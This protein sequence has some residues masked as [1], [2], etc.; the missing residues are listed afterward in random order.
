LHGEFVEPESPQWTDCLALIRH[1]VYHLPEYLRFAAR[2]QE[3]GQP[4]A[5][6]AQEEGR[7]FFLPILVRAIP[8]ALVGSQAML[9][10]ATSPRG[11]AGPV[12][13]PVED[14]AVADFTDRA[15]EAFTEA[16]RRRNIVTVFVRL[17]PLLSPTPDILRRA[18]PVIEHGHSVS[19]D[20]GLSPD[21][22]WQQTRHNHRRDISKAVRLGYTARIDH[23]WAAM[24]AFVSAYEQ[25]M[26]RLG[27]EPFWRLS[28]IYFDELRDSLDGRLHL[29]IAEVGGEVAAAAL[30]T[31]V[32]GIVEYHLAGTADAHVLASP[33]KLIVDFARRW[34]KERGNRY[35]HLGGSLRQDDSLS[36]FKAGFSPLRHPVSSWR[37]IVDRSAYRSL[38]NRWQSQ[39]G[40]SADPVSGYFP[41]YRKPR[42]PLA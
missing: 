42:S 37:L 18:G 6:V 33:S 25:S 9:L 38:S 16:C 26:D 23:D 15:I 28:R 13:G 8:P 22:L 41:A 34:A 20:L 5:F 40:M 11:Y 12:V 39:E 7:W 19:I 21:E 17:H 2:M 24:Q 32:D 31:E 4:L 3:P 29:C 27:A 30:L 36:H 35:L 14:P 1:D 10:D